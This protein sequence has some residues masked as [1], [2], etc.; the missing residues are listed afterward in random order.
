MVRGPTLDMLPACGSQPS[1]SEGWNFGEERSGMA[2]AA[3][4]EAERTGGERK[5]E[6]KERI[7]GNGA[8]RSLS[9]ASDQAEAWQAPLGALTPATDWVQAEY[10]LMV[11]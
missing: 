8:L 4:E 3:T 6:D 7:H 1:I 11:G 5:E 2:S 10:S 9:S